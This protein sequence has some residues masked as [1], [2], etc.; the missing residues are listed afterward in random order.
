MKMSRKTKRRWTEIEKLAEMDE[1]EE[2]K[3][4]DVVTKDTEEDMDQDDPNENESKDEETR[5]EEQQS[6]MDVDEETDSQEALEQQSDLDQDKKSKGDE[7]MNDESNQKTEDKK[8]FGVKGND[9]DKKEEEPK[10]EA[11]SGTESQEERSMAENM[12]SEVERLEVVEGSAT[13]EEG[14][15]SASVFRHV[16]DEKEEDRSALDKL[17]E[18][19]EVKEQVLPQDWDMK[20][21]EEREERVAKKEEEEREK[22]KKKSA[23]GAENARDEDVEME[24]KDGE[25]DE[26]EEEFTR[27]YDVARGAESLAVRREMED[28][29]VSRSVTE[30]PDSISLQPISLTDQEGEEG[31]QGLAQLS[32][33]L[34]EQLR[35]I[36]EPTK[37]A[38]LQGDFRTGKRL[39]M[40]KIIP[41]ITSQFK[42]DKIWL[43][44]V[45]PNKREFQIVIA[46]DD[47]SSMA[48]NK[49]RE[50]ALSS[51]STISSALTLLEVGQIGV[52]GFGNK[53]KMVQPLQS[54]FSAED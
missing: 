31:S 36:L 54:N 41:Y 2:E 22:D 51:L 6:G 39:N 11:G 53:A 3:L 27:T 44:R 35:L 21:P 45:K 17:K 26:R 23:N 5:N 28:V 1:K 10:Q 46:L 48:D 43:R 13:G 30:L 38:K 37:A 47:S 15:G 20:K 40:R 19:E 29:V 4:D 42:K 49:S 24:D 34:C 7:G 50:M 18:D 8:S 25:K 9:D 52:L 16:M 14:K 32:H 12:N 33:Q